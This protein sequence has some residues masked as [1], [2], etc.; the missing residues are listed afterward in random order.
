MKLTRSAFTLAATLLAGSA[1]ALQPAQPQP[2]PQPQ[3]AQPPA[4]PGPRPPAGPRPLPTAPGQPR[5]PP[6]TQ[7]TQASRP[8]LPPPPPPPE[9]TPPNWASP[10]LE[11]IGAML[12]GSWKSASSVEQHDGKGKADI[13]MHIHPIVVQGMDSTLY[14]EN[15]RADAPSK[16]YRQAIFQ[17]Y[18]YKG[19]PRLRTYT[20]APGRDT[21]AMTGMWLVP[22]YLPQIA[23]GELTATLDVELTPSGNGYAGK[24]PYPYPTS[25]HGA[26]EMTSDV[27]L[28]ADTLTT[29]DRGYD[30][31]GKIVWG[32]SETDSY[33][34]KKTQPPYTAEKRDNGLIIISMLPGE[35]SAQKIAKGDRVAIHY[36]G[37]Y[38]NGR[39][40]ESSRPRGIPLQYN[41]G[42]G[43]VAGMTQGMDGAA[44]GEVRRLVIPWELGYGAAGNRNFPPYSNLIFDTEVM[45][46]QT[47]EPAPEAPPAQPSTEP[48]AEPKHDHE[49]PAEPQPK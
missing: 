12:T 42:A 3:P 32:A 1:L 44:K 13:W 22:E 6:P 33:T 43:M 35:P 26:V 7:P 16:P 48:A 21:G 5:T 23:G 47:P 15:S 41:Q 24:T 28:T 4:N 34:F 2:Q 40:F 9:F 45:S 17:L 39:M 29:K 11:K 10:E 30:A 31:T 27:Q 18:S 36:T 20:F 8:E 38:T 14:V 19:K 25:T 37:W 46:I 49:H